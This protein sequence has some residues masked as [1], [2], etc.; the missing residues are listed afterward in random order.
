MKHLKNTVQH[1]AWGDPSAIAT[2][3]GESNPEQK[4]YAELWMGTHPSA[5]SRVLTEDCRLDELLGSFL[6]YLMKV[7]AAAKP[8]SLQV[9]PRKEDAERGYREEKDT[10][11][12]LRNYHDRN[13][14]PEIIYAL[15]DFYALS[16]F[17]DFSQISEDIQAMDLPSPAASLRECFIQYFSARDIGDTLPLVLRAAQARSKPFN[18]FWWIL[19]LQNFFPGDS[20]ILSPLFLNLVHLPPG[21]ALFQPSGTLHAYLR[22]SGIEL[23]AASDNVLRAG[24]T[25]K[26]VDF[27][28]LLKVSSFDSM[29]IVL[30]ESRNPHPK[31]EEFPVPVKDFR[32]VRLTP[33]GSLRITRKSLAS[34]LLCYQG[35]VRLTSSTQ[36][37]E[38]TRGQSLI[39]ELS[40]T[41]IEIR[42]KGT[43]FLASDGNSPQSFT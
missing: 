39:L 41:E 8:L 40:D 27:Q 43:L 4:P 22:G 3:L 15:E 12:D 33:D 31:V 16:G 6:P 34:I 19:Q 9:H 35:H 13:H 11:Q 18:R 7:L 5:P 42:G 24:C 36:S 21:N 2:L 38:L 26:R 29:D 17:R 32:L 14:K 20:G 37:M 25:N 23:M 30:V 1:Y 10:P 28:E